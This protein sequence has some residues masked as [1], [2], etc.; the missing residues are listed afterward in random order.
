MVLNEFGE[1]VHCTWDDLPNHIGG[2]ELDSFV[3]MPNHV[4]GIIVITEVGTEPKDRASSEP[5]LTGTSLLPEIV[6]QLKT[7]SA[8]RINQRR[9]VQGLSVWQRNYYEHII[10]DEK[11]LTRIREYIANNPVNWQS[12]ENYLEMPRTV[13]AENFS[14]TVKS[15][16]GKEGNK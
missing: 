15:R 4:H 11:D 13:V 6:R 7:F 14:V 5:A 3:V 8:R 10:R 12:D 9:G 2:I 1:I 16:R